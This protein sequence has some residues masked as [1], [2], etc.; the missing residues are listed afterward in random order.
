M[1]PFR[2]LWLRA[3]VLT[4]TSIMLGAGTALAAAPNQEQTQVNPLNNESLL[5][6]AG[7]LIA[8]VLSLVG[9]AVI[10]GL[11][12]FGSRFFHRNVPTDEEMATLRAA[13]NP[14]SKP[15]R[16][17]FKL[18]ARNEPVLLAAGMFVVSLALV[19]LFLAMTPPPRATA[20]EQAEAA[21]ASASLPT[22]GDFT[23]IVN[24]LPPGNADNGKTLFNSKGCVG[25]HSLDKDVRMVGPSFYNVFDHAK[26]RVPDLGPKEYLYDSIVKPNDHIVETYQSGLMPATFA[27]QLTPQDMADLLAWFERDHQGQP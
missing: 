24:E 12:Q 27:S 11:A 16:A 22:S 8:L 6:L 25:C 2:S 23:Q 26:T 9:G 14:A 13:F 19:S 17:P 3:G 20:S 15:Q 5:I 7:V 1:T 10:A 4:F 18:T 21:P